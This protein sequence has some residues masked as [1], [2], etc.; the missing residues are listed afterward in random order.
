MQ[1]DAKVS[2]INNVAEHPFRR[3]IDLCRTVADSDGHGQEHNLVLTDEQTM[4]LHQENNVMTS[5][6]A[7]MHLAGDTDSKH[8]IADSRFQAYAAVGDDHVIKRHE[9][10]RIRPVVRYAPAYVTPTVVES[11][12]PV[13]E[14]AV[15]SVNTVLE[16]E[17]V[18]LT[19]DDAAQAPV[20]EAGEEAHMLKRDGYE[21][22]LS[23]MHNLFD[24]DKLD[25][26]RDFVLFGGDDDA[27][28]TE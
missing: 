6:L 1:S 8:N 10:I 3:K 11:L 25:Q 19:E 5:I 12:P 15:D 23:Q 28:I 14:L 17:V 26:H 9:T 27:A 13:V 24:K 16:P 20:V 18:V 7:G 21:I 4:E 22:D 2:T